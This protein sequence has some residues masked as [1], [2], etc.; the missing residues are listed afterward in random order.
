MNDRKEWGLREIELYNNGSDEYR[1]MR[2]KF[3]NIKWRKLIN[4]EKAADGSLYYNNTYKIKNKINNKVIEINK[5]HN[6]YI[7]RSWGPDNKIILK[8]GYSDKL[9]KRLYTYFNHNPYIELLYTFYKPNA[10]D[11][12][13]EIHSKV[14]SDFNN[15]WYNEDKLEI[16]LSLIHDSNTSVVE[17]EKLS[18]NTNVPCW[19]TELLNNQE[20]TFK[21][22][23]KTFTPIFKERGLIFSAKSLKDYFPEF[24]KSRKIKNKIRDTY[25]KFKL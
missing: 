15:E 6:L 2:E 11:L 23:S 17:H 14:K 20:Y 10:R 9:E 19:I 8:F 24:D 16:I 18:V 3:Y 13:L 7:L 12:E 22:L 5:E 25:Y 1:E 4:I 21:E